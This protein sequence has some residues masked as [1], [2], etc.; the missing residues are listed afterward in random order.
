MSKFAITLIAAGALV[1]PALLVA[2]DNPGNSRSKPNSYVPHPHSKH[3]VYGAPMQPAVVGHIK[4]SHPNH[5]LKTQPSND[6][7]A[8]P[9]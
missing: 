9:P 7:A 1:Q 4:T 6:P 2:A 5:R 8:I 3:H